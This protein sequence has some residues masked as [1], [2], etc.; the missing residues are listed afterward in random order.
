[1]QKIETTEHRDK[2]TT[3]CL[4]DSSTTMAQEFI[5]NR[6]E[7]H[8]RWGDT[9]A[10]L[11]NAI[12]GDDEAAAK[13]DAFLSRF[14]ALNLVSSGFAVT[15]EVVGAVPNVPAF[16]SGAPVNMRLRRRIV[17]EMAPLAIIIDLTT[18]GGIAQDAMSK[19]GSVILAAARVLSATRPVELWTFVGLG[20]NH[21]GAVFAGHRL[22]TSPMDLARAA[23]CFADAHWARNIGYGTCHANGSNGS[24]PYNGRALDAKETE[25]VLR[26]ALPH[27]ADALVIPGMMLHDPLVNNPE[28]WLADTIAQYA[29]QAHAA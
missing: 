16:L 20:A 24:W 11:R 25:T 28:K 21:G 27:L 2:K 26:L 7:R 9:S 18:S 19:R 14:E 23:P 17:R 1:M 10:T 3:F 12:E 5:A 8:A 6:W 4:F 29:P 22:E 13:S 15:D